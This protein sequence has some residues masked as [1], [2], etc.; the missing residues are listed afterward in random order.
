LEQSQLDGEF[1]AALDSYLESDFYRALKMFKRV[2]KLLSNSFECLT[3]VGCCYL[4]LG[5]KPAALRYLTQAVSIAKNEISVFDLALAYVFQYEFNAALS[6]LNLCWKVTDPDFESLKKYVEGKTGCFQLKFSYSAVRAPVRY[7]S[8]LESRM[9]IKSDSEGPVSKSTVIRPKKTFYRIVENFDWKK[10]SLGYKPQNQVQRTKSLNKLNPISKKQPSPKQSVSN[11]PSFPP[12]EL[13]GKS[14][15][16]KQQIFPK[17]LKKTYKISNFIQENVETSE[18]F[19]QKFFKTESKPCPDLDLSKLNDLSQNISKLTPKRLF[20]HSISET[21]SKQIISELSKPSQIRDYEILDNL[22]KKNKFFSRFSEKTRIFLLSLSKV[23][24][25]Q[26]G[27]TIISAG[28][29][30]SH[31][32]AIIKGSVVMEKLCQELGS[33]PVEVATLYD[34]RYFGE[35]S[36]VPEEE[37]SAIK[38]FQ[39]TSCRAVEHCIL[40]T[41]PKDLY[42]Q[43]LIDQVEFDIQK[44]FK[45][46]TSVDFFMGVNR[47]LLIP[48]ASALKVKKFCHG[49]TLLGTEKPPDGLFVIVSGFVSLV[50]E[51]FRV[52]NREKIT[53]RTG[54][55]GERN[56]DE[57]IIVRKQSEINQALFSLTITTWKDIFEKVHQ[58]DTCLK[59]QDKMLQVERIEYKILKENDYFACRALTLPATDPKIKVPVSKFSVVCLN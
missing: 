34:G 14:Q 1:K 37:K 35:S 23:H 13:F 12:E 32:F 19:S 50:A 42:N 8:V 21:D 39:Q 22:T 3:N 24:Q 40:I 10:L 52:V 58:E 55:R 57:R 51:G 18:V 31:M 28:E 33:H 6:S 44:K 27:K 48:L 49:D 47:F 20:S 7:S 26:A 17:P 43:V 46:L 59:Q 56:K 4:Y 29:S 38:A 30:V 15:I 2:N 41:L 11:L 53:L 5:K 45:T 9:N 36:L 25:F 54:K 16:K